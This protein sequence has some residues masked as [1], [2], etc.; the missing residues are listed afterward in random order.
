MNK[1]DMMTA[2]VAGGVGAALSAASR[3]AHAAAGTASVPE[4]PFELWASV[5]RAT[6]AYADCVDRFDIA[7]LVALFTPD[8][9]YDYAPGLV[10]K[11][12]DAVAA[13]A[14]RSLANV[15]RS[16]HSVGPPTVVTGDS[17]GTYRSTVYFTAYHQHKDGGEHTVYGRYID[18]FR[19]DGSS[20][21]LIAHRL[22]VGHAE[23]GTSAPRHWLERSPS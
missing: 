5:N 6:Q 9:V 11:G 12:R 2:I 17:P 7:G 23:V 3:S 10:M 4:I 13:G 14:R 1:R 22:T 21:L 15:V 19:I 16:S 20:A 8:C 18:D